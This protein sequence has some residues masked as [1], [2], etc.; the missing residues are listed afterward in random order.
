MPVKQVSMWTPGFTN[1][2]PLRAFW[3]HNALHI[4]TQLALL[5]LALLLYIFCPPV[6]ARLFPVFPGVMFSP[7]GLAHSQSFRPEYFNTWDMAVI[8][9]AVPALIMGAICLWGIRDF[10]VGNAAV[11]FPFPFPF[12]SHFSLFLDFFSHSIHF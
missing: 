6:W 5:L 2:P 3:R 12:L 4:A 11:S 8:A 9:Y 7:W 1:A 10:F